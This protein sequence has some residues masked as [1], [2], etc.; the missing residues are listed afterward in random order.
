M[1]LAATCL[2]LVPVDTTLA[3]DN[4]KIRVLTQNQYLGA[5]LEPL[6]TASDEVEFNLAMIGVM[7]AIGASNYPER[8][9]AL[10]QTIMDSRADLVGMQ[11]M[12]SF[13]CIPVSTTVPNPCSMFGPAFND[14]LEST[15]VALEDI[16]GGYHVAAVVQNLTIDAPLPGLPVPGIPVFL[17]NDLL[18]DIFVTVIDRDVIL[19]RDGVEAVPV[20]YDCL[21][22]S[23]DGCNYS[24]VAS[25]SIGDIPLSIERSFVAVD[26]EV[27]GRNYRFVNTHLEVRFPD[28]ANPM[29]R[30]IQS[31]QAT[32][33][34]GI[35]TVQGA[36]QGTRTLVVGDFNSDPD[37]PYP[38]PGSGPFLT[39]YQQLV[40]GLDWTGTPISAPYHD[41]WTM[42]HK[43]SPGLTCCEAADLGNETSI[44]D[45]RVDLI[46][47][48]QKPAKV[49]ARVLNTQPE[50]KTA[51]GLWPS[52]HASVVARLRFGGKRRHGHGHYAD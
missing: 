46:F 14:H 28:P 33:L 7:Q 25:T 13:G 11:E 5:N 31:L 3:R 12:W 15:L 44:H 23:F 24:T 47:A 29:S 19:A 9:Q 34:M 17:D 22:P 35:L 37:D 6:V 45:R 38:S 20:S 41:T 43:P 27:R 8:V 51:S 4:A 48:L 32:E 39:P 2:A 50:D 49:K 16:G 18:P 30:Y 10:A 42:Q 1:L 26:A 52:D 40:S 21:K 36:P